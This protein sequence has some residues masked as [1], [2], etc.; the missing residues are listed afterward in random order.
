[1]RSENGSLLMSQTDSGKSKKSKGKKSREKELTS[2]EQVDMIK[3]SKTA[4]EASLL[5]IESAELN[6]FAVECFVAIMRYMGDYAMG[7]GQ[8]E[9]DCVYFVLMVIYFNE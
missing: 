1:M 7:K 2:K 8:T 5:R 3:Y 6:K 4:I 9:V